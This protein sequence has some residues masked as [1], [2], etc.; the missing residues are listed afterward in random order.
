MTGVDWG[1]RR[2]VSQSGRGADNDHRPN[3]P[4]FSCDLWHTVCQCTDLCGKARQGTQGLNGSHLRQ[5]CSAEQGV[6]SSTGGFHGIA[7]F[8]RFYLQPRCRGGCILLHFAPRR[9]PYLLE[10]QVDD[11]HL[12]RPGRPDDGG[13]GRGGGWQAGDILLLLLLQLLHREGDV[14][15]RPWRR[16][17]RL[18]KRAFWGGGKIRSPSLENQLWIDCGRGVRKEDLLEH[19]EVAVH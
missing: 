5:K 1:L 6:E 7:A 12:G 8:L 19:T 4:F 15:R 9:L 14:A 2:H 3:W 10:S 17:L 16:L 13:G 11:V 18:L